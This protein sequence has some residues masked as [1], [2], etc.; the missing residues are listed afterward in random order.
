MRRSDLPG[1][2]RLRASFDILCGSFARAFVGL[3]GSRRIVV[4]AYHSVSESPWTHA[5]APAAFREQMRWL[6]Q[7]A[8]I[9]SI[10][11][12]ERMM[13]TG[14]SRSRRP[15]VAVTFDDGYLDWV[16]TA[17]PI[18]SELQVRATFFVTTS[19]QLVTSEP[20]TVIEPLREVDVRTLADA[21]YEI[22]SHSHTHRDLSVCTSEELRFELSESRRLLAELSKQPVNHLSYPKGRYPSDL[23]G[24]KDAGYSLAF[25]GHGSVSSETNP[26]IAPRM[27]TRRGMSLRRFVANVYRWSV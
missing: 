25:A 26:L 2:A 7:H 17:L 12:V 4:L 3:F 10:D 23:S 21:G 24:L 6:A 19:F 9:L 16:T 8:Q 15:R 5:T 22:G 27:P 14:I 13:Q 20:Q 1:Y 11:E 18:L